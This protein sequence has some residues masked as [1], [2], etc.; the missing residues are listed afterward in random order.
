[1]GGLTDKNLQL[2]LGEWARV[3]Q[4]PAGEGATWHLKSEVVWHGVVV[5]VHTRSIR[6]QEGKDQRPLSMS[7]V[8]APLKQLLAVRW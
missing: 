7:R 2:V 4:R 5:V 1:M 6:R 8:L 3:Y